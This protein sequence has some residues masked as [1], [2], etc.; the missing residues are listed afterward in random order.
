MLPLFILVVAVVLGFRDI[1]YYRRLAGRTVSRGRN[2]QNGGGWSHS[3]CWITIR[4]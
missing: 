2:L 3:P 1:R 4:Q